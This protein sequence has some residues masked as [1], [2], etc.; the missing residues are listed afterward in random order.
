MYI[1]R[2]R[3]NEAVKI[4]EK[5]VVQLLCVNAETGELTLGIVAPRGIEVMKIPSLPSLKAVTD[6]TMEWKEDED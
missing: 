4:G 5:I 1:V 3:I 6:E 2:R